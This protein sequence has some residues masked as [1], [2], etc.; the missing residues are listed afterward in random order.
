[1]AW[2]FWHVLKFPILGNRITIKVVQ[3]SGYLSVLNIWLHIQVYNLVMDSPLACSNSAG[4]LSI[5]GDF[6]LF[7]VLVA[8]FTSKYFKI[9]IA[10]VWCWCL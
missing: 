3:S 10:T 4:M 2:Q 1:M 5:P 8:I 7:M 9:F 6:T